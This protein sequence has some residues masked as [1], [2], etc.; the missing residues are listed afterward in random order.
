ML[1]I[2]IYVLYSL[3]WGSYETQKSRNG[4]TSRSLC[5]MYIII[6]CG[7]IA[8]W[9]ANTDHVRRFKNPENYFGASEF[10]FIHVLQVYGWNDG[11]YNITTLFLY[12]P[13]NVITVCPD[14]IFRRY[15][16]YSIDYLYY[17]C[18]VAPSLLL[19]FIQ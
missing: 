13:S 18:Y 16:E 3:C 19:Y 9:A 5:T 6:A 7:I 10:F 4:Q 11:D 8:Y 1:F 2:Y 17:Y 15:M 14:W 12:C